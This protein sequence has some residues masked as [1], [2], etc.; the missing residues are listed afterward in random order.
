MALASYN[1]CILFTTFQYCPIAG[2]V[3]V[4]YNIIE[5]VALHTMVNMGQ[6]YVRGV[7]GMS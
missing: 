5:N 7:A 4:G 1:L 2:V 6:Y 3:N